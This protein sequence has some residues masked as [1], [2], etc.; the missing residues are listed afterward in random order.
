MASCSITLLLAI[1]NRWNLI[2]GIGDQRVGKPRSA[3]RGK[4]EV[5]Q[6]VILQ[7]AIFTLTDERGKKKG[8]CIIKSS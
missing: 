4:C 2:L 5:I 6:R 7:E 3:E 8:K 1:S